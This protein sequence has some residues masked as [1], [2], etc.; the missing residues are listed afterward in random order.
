M[1]TINDN[2]TCERIPGLPKISTDAC[3]ARYRKANSPHGFVASRG[4]MP[5]NPKPSDFKVYSYIHC[6]KCPV[7]KKNA[8]HVYP[9]QRT[10]A[11]HPPGDS[12]MCKV[13]GETLPLDQFHRDRGGK[14][15]R[16]AICIECTKEFMKK[17]GKE[18]GSMEAV[19]VAEGKT[20]KGCGVKKPLEQYQVNPRTKDGLQPICKDCTGKKIASGRWDKDKNHLHLDISDY[21]EIMEALPDAAKARIRTLELQAIAYIVRGLQR[22]GYGKEVKA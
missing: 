22:D 8:A 9:R 13:C 2:F 18:R 14:F 10:G 19:K 17:K 16:K 11:A 15:G 4:A 5:D 6:W 3:A 20:C 1:P 12:K 21:P 7:G